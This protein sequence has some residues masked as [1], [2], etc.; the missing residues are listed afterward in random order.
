MHARGAM[1]EPP[2][3]STGLRGY[4]ELPRH[5]AAAPEAYEKAH[6]SY[7]VLGLGTRGAMVGGGEEIGGGTEGDDGVCKGGQWYKV[8]LLGGHRSPHKEAL[9]VIPSGPL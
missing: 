3:P 4:W 6:T 5:A 9:G 2:T 1:A 8:R 7:A